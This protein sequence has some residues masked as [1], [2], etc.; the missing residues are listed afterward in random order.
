MK[1][2][3]LPFVL[4]SSYL[5]CSQQVGTAAP[6]MGAVENN[7]YAN[8]HQRWTPSMQKLFQ[9]VKDDDGKV[10]H[11][12]GAE[13]GTPYEND[14]FEIGHVW[15]KNEDLG[16]FYYRYNIF[17]NEIELKKTHLTEEKHQALIRDPNVVL[18]ASIGEKA[19]HYLSFT[20]DKEDNKEGYLIKLYQ[21]SEF[22][23]FKHLESKYT[24][25]KP[26]ANS[27]VNPT[28]SKFTTFNSYFLQQND[29]QIKEISLKR[30]KFLKQL[31]SPAAEKMKIY[32]KEEKTD[33][34]EERQ[35][36]SAIAHL[37]KANL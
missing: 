22:K 31:D 2:L 3:I 13:V 37:D 26:A 5:L 29:G 20:A 19:Y 1:K 14:T 8:F 30:N 35:L 34:S 23:L 18:T 27:M 21:G 4:L 15:Y 33:L 32:F 6:Q 11:F 10:T 12:V 9:L 25:A 16:E 28:P 7:P 24:E 17:S 36:I